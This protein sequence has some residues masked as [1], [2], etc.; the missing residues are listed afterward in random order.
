MDPRT[1]IGAMIQ[2]ADSQ[3]KTAVQMN[4]LTLVD[5]AGYQ[6]AVVGLD[7]V[8][9]TCPPTNQVKFL[10]FQIKRFLEITTLSAHFTE[11]MNHASNF[12]LVATP[13]E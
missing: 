11:P 5:P 6:W 13:F 12:A 4:T 3:H 9:P 1:V 8:M 10:E 7:S 2:E